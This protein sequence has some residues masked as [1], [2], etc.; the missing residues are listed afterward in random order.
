[1]VE[2]NA[3][4]VLEADFLP[5]FSGTLR[6][7]SRHWYR[8]MLKPLYIPVHDCLACRARRC[9][10]RNQPLVH[11][12]RIPPSMFPPSRPWSSSHSKG[13]H[14]G[15]RRDSSFSRMHHRPVHFGWTE[16]RSLFVNLGRRVPLNV[17]EL[18]REAGYGAGV[19]DSCGSR[20][21]LCVL[22][23]QEDEERHARDAES[24]GESPGIS[25]LGSGVPC[26]R[27]Q[28]ALGSSVASSASQLL[29]R[30]RSM[31]QRQAQVLPRSQLSAPSTDPKLSQYAHVHLEGA[32]LGERPSQELPPPDILEQEQ[33]EECHPPKRMV[34]F[35]PFM[36]SKR[37]RLVVSHGSIDLEVAS[38]SC[39]DLS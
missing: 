21:Q 15:T 26:L 9:Q 23:H 22:R 8:R 20:K 24:S 16:Q 4:S 36:P 5:P 39:E 19:T 12:A 11:L 2:G 14:F 31:T 25:G 38:S 35:P 37:L 3:G 30:T 6:R 33:A 7:S 17:A 34:S 29:C 18:Q 32:R 27:D 13:V 10:L 28:G 1:M